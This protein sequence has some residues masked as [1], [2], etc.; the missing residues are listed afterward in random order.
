M[1]DASTVYWWGLVVGVGGWVG[2]CVVVVAAGRC[3]A[4]HLFSSSASADIAEVDPGHRAMGLV[5]LDTS[6][7][8]LTL[9][10][11]LSPRSS[12]VALQAELA[13]MDDLIHEKQGLIRHAKASII[14][15]DA[16]IEQLLSNVVRT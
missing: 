9:R 3:A 12:L 10:V 14:R 16:T 11:S 4:G 13:K 2:G 5:H 6:G 7:A 15:N 8:T 1:G